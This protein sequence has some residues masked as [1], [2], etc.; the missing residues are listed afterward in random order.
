MLK[1]YFKTTFRNLAKNK[2]HTIINIVGLSF[3][4][5]CVLIIYLIINFE[6]SFD[7][8]HTNFESIYRIVKE[9]S[10]FGETSF[11]T[12]VPYP[13]PPAMRADFPEIEFLTIV[14]C[15]FNSP[16]ISVARI[17]GSVAKFQEDEGVAFVE[18]D[19][20]RIFDYTWL[21][22]DP[23]SA[24]KNPNSAVLSEGLARKYFG[25]DDPMGKILTYNNS[26]EFQVTAVV[27]DVPQNTDI[28]FNLLLAYDEAVR[29]NDNWGS[30]AS[31]VQCYLKLPEHLLPNQIE[32][33]LKAFLTKHRNKEA[34][35]FITHRMQPLKSMHYDT[36]FS[37]YGHRTVAK[38]TLLALGLIGIFLLF[39][40]CINFINLNTAVAVNRSKEVGVRKVL[41]GTRAQ[42]TLHFLSETAF[43]TLLAIAISIASIEVILPKLK[44]FLGYELVTNLFRDGGLLL[45]LLVLFVAVSVIAGFYPALHLSG[46]NPIEAIRNK[47]TSQYGEGLK[48]RKGLVVLQ[49]AISQVLII[50]TIVISSQMAYFRNVDMGFQKDAVVEVGL[51]A[52]DADKIQRFKNRLLQY[53]A[54]KH[55]SFSN[56]GTASS[57]TWGGNYDW[58]NSDEKKDG[59][60]Q[61]KFVDPDFL[62]TYQIEL[63]AGEGLVP[64]PA[65]TVD[66]FLVNQ[67][68]V[69]EIG[70]GNRYAD[71]LGK[72]TK[73]WGREAP[74]VGVVKN[75]NTTSLHQKISPVIIA[76]QNR[77]W[78][79]GIKIEMQDVKNTLAV[80]EESWSSVYPEFVFDYGFLDENIEKFY[81][82]EQRVATMINTFTIIAVL[83]GCLGLFGLVSYMASQ[84]TKEIGIRKVLGATFSN[85]LTLL[86]KEF[87]L[88]VMI[89]FFIAAPIAYYFMEAWLADFAYRIELGTDLFALALFASCAIAFMAV[90]YKSIRTAGAN[91]VE[92]L[93]N[94]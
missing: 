20:F 14:D 26:L 46:F 40:A 2:T 5:V 50:G 84:R 22:G 65:D 53:P 61:I 31:S 3:G 42:L 68:F 25:D 18:P 15:N 49:F 7:R 93:R 71:V 85:I 27:K 69:E 63:L 24:L 90:G 70:Y 38:E 1:N 82:D 83:I 88:L 76:V 9:D 72:Y 43:I 29:G 21:T 12:G 91:P 32:S 92:S 86:S 8:Y 58:K 73:I 33:Q 48:L 67:A 60:A 75:F 89:A 57:N 17:D 80:I 10:Q 47:M 54:I 64:A 35:E 16:V 77:Y 66:R 28:P 41:G 59:H 36:R 94:E 23:E 44:S 55:V 87:A 30:T 4:I 37:T 51:P 34:A 79:A 56:T 19:Y 52:N 62:E 13:L 74:V 45:F 6:M 78:M 81:D 11:D 39:T